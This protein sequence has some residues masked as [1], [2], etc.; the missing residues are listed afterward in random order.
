MMPVS[1]WGLMGEDALSAVEAA[2]AKDRERAKG[3]GK[4]KKGNNKH[5]AVERHTTPFMPAP[6]VHRGPRPRSP[7][8]RAGGGHFREV[9]EE[10]GGARGWAGR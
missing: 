1:S 6:P 4:G 9:E 5:G 2:T 8:L 7:S 3:K 10:P